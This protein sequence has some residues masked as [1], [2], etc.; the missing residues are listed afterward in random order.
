MTAVKNE[1]LMKSA[2]SG[3]AANDSRK[4]EQIFNICRKS[5]KKMTL[6][7]RAFCEAYLIDNKQRPLKLR[8]LQESIIVKTLT[9]PDGDADKP[10][11]LAILAPRG[12]G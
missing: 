8:P 1:N 11:K 12:S 10:R 6:L 5:E 3:M 9:Y 2:I 4:L 7:V